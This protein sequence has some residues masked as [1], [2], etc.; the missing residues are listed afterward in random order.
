[1]SL[2]FIIGGSGAGKTR[3]LYENLIERAMAEPE[4]RFFAI[5]P[6]QFS[7]QTQK[8]IVSL[9]PSHGV[10][11]IDILSFQ[12]LAYRVFEELAVETRTV[13]DDMGKSLVIRRVVSER[14]NDLGLY[15]SHL[16]KPGFIEKLKSMIS[17]FYQYGVDA[18]TLKKMEEQAGTR[19]LKEK[20]RDMQV[21]FLGFQEFIEKKYITAEEV[22]DVLS[23]MIPR[24]EILKDSVVTL[25]GFVD[26]TPVQYRVL[27]QLML[28][29]RQVV[30]TAIVDAGE[31]PYEAGK[32]QELFHMSRR[33]IRKLDSL[34]AACNVPRD[35]DILLNAVPGWR[36]RESPGLAYLE[37]HL[38]RSR[39]G[40]GY[41]GKPEDIFIRRAK[42][43]QEEVEAVL[44]EIC[45][46]VREEGYRYREIAVVT[47][48]LPGYQNELERQFESQQIPFFL[49]DKRQVMGDPLVEFIRA[50]LQVVVKDFSYESVFRY[51]KTGL[52]P[53]NEQVWRLE[54]Y[55][56][57]LG[58]RGFKR[59]SGP[60]EQVYAGAEHLN[61]ETLNACREE[62]F[63]PLAAFREELRAERGSVRSMVL[64]LVH[65]LQSVGAQEKMARFEAEIKAAGD[66]VQAMEYGQ[67]Y[68]L[69]MELLDRMEGLLGDENMPLK[70]FAKVLDAGFEEIRVGFIPATVDRVVIGDITRTRLDHV[71]VL[72][73]VGANDGIIPQAKERNGILTDI[74][75]TFLKEQDVE[76]APTAREDGFMQRFYL[77]LM[78]TKPSDRL[79]ISYADMSSAGKGIRPSSL[80][81][82]LQRMFPQLA[83]DAVDG[84]DLSF[85]TAKAGKKRLVE[86][87]RAFAGLADEKEFLEL[88]RWFFGSDEYREQVKELLEAAFYSYEERGIGRLAARELYGQI[89]RG[90]VTRLERYAA[91]AYAHFL[92][93]GL[94]LKERREY[95]LEA[96]DLGN[97]FHASLDR[98]FS[99]MREEKIS[100]RG[101]EEETRK[102]LVARCVSEVTGQYGNTIMESSSR[103]AYLARRVERITDRTVWALAE[104]LKKG[105]FEP[106][107][108]EVEFSAAD[109][110]EAMKIP[111]G[112]GEALHLRGRIDRLDTLDDGGSIYVKIIDYKSG[113]TKFDLTDLYYGLQLQL[114]VYMD[115]AME[116][117]HRNQ[118]GKK[119][120][121]AGLFYYNIKD[122]VVE[123]DEEQDTD[124]QIL[125]ALR[126]NGLVNSRLEVIRHMDREIES[127]SD[128]IP[129]AMKKG[130]I[131]EARSSVATE[132]RFSS[133][134]KF[135]RGRLK[136][137]GREI[138]SGE[139]AVRPYKRGER[140][141]CDYCPYHSVCGFDLKTEGFGYKRLKALKSE[142]IWEEIEG[143]KEEQDGDDMD[144]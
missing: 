63:A 2:Q 132:E 64:A 49:D 81:G 34:A 20:L 128:V 96:V 144:R 52:L 116:L 67:V 108:F 26:F 86:G 70:E 80:I 104:Q 78:M 118:P 23:R 57:A 60:W 15:Q 136:D 50:A 109:H 1:M 140:T 5:V 58:I 111:L 38:F 113:A 72:F 85:S 142:T 45:R 40:N 62:I 124:A 143:G 39:P 87:L 89:L 65:F 84:G 16:D 11:N 122:P 13:L 24:S 7:M 130:L 82:R 29:S 94:E 123:R 37:Q 101:L 126:M 99:V 107:G 95:R 90:S 42:N 110:L 47:G 6:E 9:H 135:V 97:L 98:F 74:E 18:E 120:V 117:E 27:E 68:G 69:V 14:K 4:R 31:K 30:V 131:Q 25:D 134:R 10:A 93:F 129:V 79:W 88:Y 43:P 127:E 141:A 44:Q 55:V 103:N 138:L 139:T 33:T 53:L 102:K 36:F 71:K 59:W 66:P 137:F 46:C 21:V 3:R 56:R 41:P 112:G 125:K 119:I 76:L 105:D 19:I 106:A 75:R 35:K 12:R 28:C 83:V 48:D 92:G 8:E 61:L 73:L 121:P 77:Y 115:A 133:L 91:C 32:A 100:W 17:E 22:L 54:N 51:I 114:V